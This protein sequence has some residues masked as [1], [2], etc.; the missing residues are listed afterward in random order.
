M[1]APAESRA[2]VLRRRTKRRMMTRLIRART[3]ASGLRPMPDF[4]I[5]GAQ[6]GGTSSLFKYLEGHP[7]LAASVRKE[8]EYFS[9]RYGEGEAWYRAHFPIRRGG[10]VHPFEA[11]PDYLFY[12]PTPQRVAADLP[13]ARFVVLLRDPIERA[14]SHYRHMRRLG[15]EQL[16]FEQAIREEPARIGPDASQLERDPLHYPRPLLRYSYAARGRYAEQLERWFAWFDPS[17]FLIARSEDLF[18]DPATVFASVLEFLDLRPWEPRAFANHSY[19]TS[20][21]GSAVVPPEPAATLREILER[22]VERLEGLLG[23]PMGWRLGVAE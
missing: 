12:P 10:R 14:F 11:T 18:A 23:R 21:E 1:S 16:S 5:I 2:A 6:R 15:F 20:P 13:D 9:R 8:T 19:R 17:R 22:D 7:D 4:M 3:V